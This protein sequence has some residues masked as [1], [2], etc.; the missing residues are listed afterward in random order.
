MS[1]D[2]LQTIGESKSVNATTTCNKTATSNNSIC[3]NNSI[4]ADRFSCSSITDKI[5]KHGVL[6]PQKVNCRHY[7]I[8]HKSFVGVVKIGFVGTDAK[9]VAA[10]HS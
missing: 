10:F 8:N 6:V 7:Y 1:H 3:R 9:P 2:M 5:I 4:V